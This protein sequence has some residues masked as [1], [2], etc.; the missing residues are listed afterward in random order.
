[1][2]WLALSDAEWTAI[3]LSLRVSLVAMFV[4]LPFAIGIAMLLARGRFWGNP[5]SMAWS[6]SP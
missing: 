1:M 4:S 2:D 5:S 6:I 3:H